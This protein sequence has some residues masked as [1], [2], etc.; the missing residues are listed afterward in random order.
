M[1]RQK[2]RA[3]PQHVTA[4]DECIEVE[5]IVH[6]AVAQPWNNG[7]ISEM[8]PVSV[9]LAKRD[10]HHPQVRI[11]WAG[12]AIDLDDLVRVRAS[13]DH[14]KIRPAVAIEITGH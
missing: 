8:Q 10:E 4:Y 7:G 6:V 2:R 5:Q 1:L 12:D 3:E 14:G 9:R 13:D 11:E